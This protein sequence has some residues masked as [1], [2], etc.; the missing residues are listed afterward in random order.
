MQES[1]SVTYTHHLGDL[2]N[3]LFYSGV[4]LCTCLV[5]A[6]QVSEAENFLLRVLALKALLCLLFL[7]EVQLVVEIRV[8]RVRRKLTHQ[9]ID[10]P[11]LWLLF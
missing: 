9:L 8:I 6:L 3:K 5:E 10:M 7:L 11:W 4:V 2:L 1:V